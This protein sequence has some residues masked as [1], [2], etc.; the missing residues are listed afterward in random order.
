MPPPRPT[1]PTPAIERRA[2]AH[3]PA[4]RRGRRRRWRWRP[5]CRAP[6]RP[7]RAR[8]A[9]A[10]ARRRR[11]PR[12]RRR[13]PTGG[14][15]R[16]A[17]AIGAMR[18]GRAPRAA[19]GAERPAL[20]RRA[21]RPPGRSLL[22][23]DRRRRRADADHRHQLRRAQPAAPSSDG[24]SDRATLAAADPLLDEMAFSRGRFLVQV[25]RAGRTWSCPTWPELARVIEECRAIKNAPEAGA[26][27]MES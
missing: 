26:R 24:A 6:R 27:S 9:A 11:R 4:P 20:R 3:G 15:R 19:F 14:T 1:R 23:R 16:S 18:D 22:A 5:A 10:P 12:P 8:A 7:P 25:G 2:D 21:A 13:R 17:R